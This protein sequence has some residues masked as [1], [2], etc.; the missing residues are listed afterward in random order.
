MLRQPTIRS[1]F[2]G[3]F[4]MS[5]QEDTGTKVVAIVVSTIIVAILASVIGFA[6]SRSGAKPA[7][8]AAVAEV[9]D[10]A[11]VRVEDGVVKFF[12]ATGKA[13]VAMGANEAL[14][15]VVTAVSAGQQAVISGF[16]DA[17]GDP[18]QNAELAKQRAIAVRDALVAL[19]V[20]QDKVELKKPEEAMA[21]GPANEARRVEVVV[22]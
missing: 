11:S 1:I 20:P 12:F 5:E 10:A 22:K 7:P 4:D 17:S 14:A 6:V 9:A 18:V 3:V 13:D 8:A 19:G 16:H 21:T 15:N 2:K